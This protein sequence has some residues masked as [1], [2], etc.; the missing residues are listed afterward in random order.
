MVYHTIESSSLL[1]ESNSFNNIYL[2][3]ATIQSLYERSWANANTVKKKAEQN[4]RMWIEI[5]FLWKEMVLKISHKLLKCLNVDL[6]KVSNKA[7]YSILRESSKV[8]TNYEEKPNI[9][10]QSNRDEVRLNLLLSR[11]R[12]EF[13]RKT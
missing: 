2:D 9:S 4:Y 5:N 11:L 13:Q 3:N 7:V 10:K 6:H 1:N 12:V 8:L